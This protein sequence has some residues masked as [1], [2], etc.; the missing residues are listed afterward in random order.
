MA[1]PQDVSAI[2]ASIESQWS[3]AAHNWNPQMLTALYTADALLMG[4]RPEH[5]VGQAAIRGYFDSYVGI[6]H[7][8]GLE[9]HE[10]E[11]RMLGAR[12]MLAQ[13]FA[14]FR[15][16]L[17]GGVETRMPVRTTFLLVREDRWRIRSHHFSAIPEAPPLGN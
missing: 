8:G 6:I 5:S 9:F 7:S 16:I 3:E 11:T 12:A 10:Q 13:G 4:G 2:L 15:F 1:D 14:T 17:A